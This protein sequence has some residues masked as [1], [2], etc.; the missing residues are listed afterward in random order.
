MTS[1]STASFVLVATLVACGHHQV[2]TPAAAP[3]TTASPVVSTPPPDPDAAPS[4]HAFVPIDGACNYAH[5]NAANGEPVQQWAAPTPE[6]P[7]RAFAHMGPEGAQLFSV[8]FSD[9]SA[10]WRLDVGATELIALPP[11][12]H[13]EMAWS[14]SGD[15]FA[16]TYGDKADEGIESPSA[17]PV[18][19]S[20][21]PSDTGHESQWS[22]DCYVYKLSDAG[23]MLVKENT[24]ELAEGE[25]RPYCH[26]PDITWGST[27]NRYHHFNFEGY[28]DSETY[29]PEDENEG[30]GIVM[31]MDA[32]RSGI[33]CGQDCPD[34]DLLRRYAFGNDWFEGPVLTGGV[35]S[36]AGKRG[37]QW[38]SVEG[39]NGGVRE[40]FVMNGQLIL[41]SENG[42]GGW[43]HATATPTWWKDTP[44][45]PIQN[46]L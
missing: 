22:Q 23:W 40:F 28:D 16:Q 9:S 36:V 29:P 44:I 32:T 27:S 37:S 33:P 4:I 5:L 10:A 19:V 46:G 42:F 1:I 24:V 17:E 6:C 13:M 43:D 30:F 18:V 20:E 38:A 26:Y 34:G 14:E 31:E 25:D 7:N 2:P 41:C 11:L 15:V 21:E 12:S 8:H 35:I 39:L 45:C 3:P